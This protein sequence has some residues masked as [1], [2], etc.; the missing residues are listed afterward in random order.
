MFLLTHS[1]IG[2]DYLIGFIQAINLL[3]VRVPFFPF[4]FKVEKK[5]EKEKT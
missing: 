4:F 5:V 3:H 1:I 2:A